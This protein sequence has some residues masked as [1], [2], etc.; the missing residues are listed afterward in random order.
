MPLRSPACQDADAVQAAYRT[1]RLED[2]GPQ[3]DA[4]ARALI[5]DLRTGYK[6]TVSFYDDPE[7]EKEV[8][9]VP[10]LP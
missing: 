4:R 9:D 3:A 8:A 2:P 10:G 6:P 1:R 5:E 7:H